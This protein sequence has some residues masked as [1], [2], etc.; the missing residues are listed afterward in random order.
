MED[1]RKLI[2]KDQIVTMPGLHN[3]S[4]EFVASTNVIVTNILSQ[5]KQQV[6]KLLALND[7][8]GLK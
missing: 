7:I 2:F 1:Y 3:R 8:D 5:I 4:L 6:S